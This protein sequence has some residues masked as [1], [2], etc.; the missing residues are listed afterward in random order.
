MT[1]LSLVLATTVALVTTGTN[2]TTKV[3]HRP[4]PERGI[5]QHQGSHRKLHIQG[6]TLEGLMA[7]AKDGAEMVEFD[8]VRLGPMKYGLQH[9]KSQKILT[10]FDQVLAALPYEGLYINVH[11]YGNKTQIYEVAGMIRDSGRLH[12]AFI[13]SNLRQIDWARQAVPEIM[14]C[15]IERPGPRNRDWTDAEN[16]KFIDDSIA[17]KCQFLQLSRPWTKDWSDKA[18][19]AGIKVIYFKSDDRSEFPELF[20]R[21]IDFIM[22]DSV[23][24]QK[25]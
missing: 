23:A 11:C 19:A 2:V 3:T 15:N 10:T 4:L 13:C 25:Q 5:C 14:T 21:G 24:P 7:A 20:A 17:H 22:T 8:L 16:Q 9:D 18:H 6:N 1:L 12:Q